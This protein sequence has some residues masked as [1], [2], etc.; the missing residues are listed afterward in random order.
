MK[1]PCFLSPVA[2]WLAL[3][4]ASVPALA[5]ADRASPTGAIEGRVFAAS[6]DSYL[7]SVRVTVANTALETRTD[8]DGVFRLAAVPAG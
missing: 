7:E 4:L 6:S 8:A 2:R 3:T 5:A 1:H